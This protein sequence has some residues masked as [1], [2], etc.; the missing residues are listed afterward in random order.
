MSSPQNFET[1]H[2]L[3]TPD[4]KGPH[5]GH[6]SMLGLGNLFPCIQFLYKSIFSLYTKTVDQISLPPAASIFDLKIEHT[7]KSQKNYLMSKFFDTKTL[8]NFAIWP[9]EHISGIKYLQ[10]RRVLK[11]L[12]QWYTIIWA[13]A[14]SPPEVDEQ[15]A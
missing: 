13:T 2:K 6:Y 9:C 12:K 3:A 15:T 11:L 4:T 1:Y 10:T 7:F 8:F 5:L 14:Q